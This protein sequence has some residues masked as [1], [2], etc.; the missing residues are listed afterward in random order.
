[1]REGEEREITTWRFSVCVG[2][3]LQKIEVLVLLVAG[4]CW[5]LGAGGNAS[6]AQS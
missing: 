6:E 3:S 4:V 1:M 2:F 5:G